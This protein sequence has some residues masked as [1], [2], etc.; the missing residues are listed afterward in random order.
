MEKS[1]CTALT[2]KCDDFSSKQINTIRSK[3]DRAYPRWFVHANILFPF[4]SKASFEL[5]K[6]QIP[7]KK[8]KLKLDGIGWFKKSSYYTFHLKFTKD[9]VKTI[10][11]YY[12]E[13][14]KSSTELFDLLNPPSQLIPHIT[15]AQGPK[16]QFNSMLQEL[17]EWY[18]TNLSNYEFEAVPTMCYRDDTTKNLMCEYNI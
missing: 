8:F 4:V 5:I 9:S 2:I 17:T 10:C 1:F 6:D 3:Y 11:E 15:V 18:Q 12:Q 13:L 7:V 16:D 14:K